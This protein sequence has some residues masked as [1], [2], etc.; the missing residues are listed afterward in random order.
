MSAVG[1]K[2][3]ISDHLKL[4]EPQPPEV[5][6]EFDRLLFLEIVKTFGVPKSLIFT[7]GKVERPLQQCRALICLPSPCLRG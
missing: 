1:Q 6:K 2:M 3:E 7:P 4:I 5:W